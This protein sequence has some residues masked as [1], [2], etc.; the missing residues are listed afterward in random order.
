M[1]HFQSDSQLLEKIQSG[2]AKAFTELFDQ[3]WDLLFHAAYGRLKSADLAKDVVQEVF[4]D[5]WNR[6]ETI[7]IKFRLDVY[8]LTAVKYQIFKMIDQLNLEVGIEEYHG[9]QLLPHEEVLPLEELYQKL[10]VALD[11][12]PEMA[13]HIFRMNKLQ[14]MSASEVAQTLDINVQSVHNSIHKSM[15]VLRNSLKYTS[16]ILLFFS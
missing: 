1:S 2:D 8:L 16:G 5:F 3:Y 10:E 6:K 9:I 14:G 4:L 13:A 11:E 7:K 12:L 15:K